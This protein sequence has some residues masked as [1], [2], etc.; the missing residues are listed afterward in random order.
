MSQDTNTTV[1]TDSSPNTDAEHNT[2]AVRLRAGMIPSIEFMLPLLAVIGQ[3]DEGEKTEPVVKTVD[4]WRTRAAT[5]VRGTQLM[6]SLIDNGQRDAILGAIDLAEADF[7][8]CL[9]SNKIPAG[10]IELLQG[11][12]R[13]SGFCQMVDKIGID[14]ANELFPDGVAVKVLVGLGSQ[15]RAAL[16]LD[17]AETISMSDIYDLQMSC[18]LLMRQGATK[19]L[20]LA[21]LNSLI[22]RLMPIDAASDNGQVIFALREKLAA[23]RLELSEIVITPVVASMSKAVKKMCANA[24]TAKARLEATIV[25][26]EAE[27]IKTILTY[28]KGTWDK[29]QAHWNCGPVADWAMHKSIKGTDHPD[30][31]EELRADINLI[32]YPKS[33]GGWVRQHA[34]KGVK[35]DWKARNAGGT[36][37]VVLSA[38]DRLLVVN[39]V[40]FTDRLKKVI[41]EKKKLIQKRADKKAANGGVDTP[42][43]KALNQTEMASVAKGATDTLAKTVKILSGVEKFET[44]EERT[45]A[46]AIVEARMSVADVLMEDDID[47]WKNTVLK[48]YQE[49]VDK[50]EADAKAKAEADAKALVAELGTDKIDPETGEEL[51]PVGAETEAAK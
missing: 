10:A 38:E 48:R 6:G 46:L 34:I 41:A 17:N 14:A 12:S 37:P 15:E 32:G 27:E 40:Q 20:V 33:S 3:T 51:A 30:C 28:R 47:F 35:A 4:N 19:K 1:T 23:L 49:C 24:V 13:T 50:R 8:A 31:P 25:E 45:E 26:I 44:P 29:L 22:E 2:P 5:F 43:A 16:K 39:G 36:F 9:E 11:H 7:R 21:Q 18:N 42:R